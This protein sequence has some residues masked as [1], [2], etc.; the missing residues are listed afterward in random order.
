VERGGKGVHAPRAALCRGR[1]LE[2]NSCRKCEQQFS[3]WQLQ[4]IKLKFHCITQLHS[5]ISILF[6]VHT[7][8]IV[9]PIRISIADLTIEGAATQTFAPGGKN[10]RAATARHPRQS[11][12]PIPSPCVVSRP[13]H[14]DHGGLKHDCCGR[15]DHNV[16]LAQRRTRKHG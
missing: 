7:N 16:N 14:F 1:H 11:R 8:A 5:Q 4:L 3:F 15:R 9:V 2:G 6:T 12:L 10:R 13:S